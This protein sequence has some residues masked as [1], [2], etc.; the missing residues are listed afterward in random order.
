EEG[1]ADLEHALGEATELIADWLGTVAWL[2]TYLQRRDVDDDTALRSVFRYCLERM[3]DAKEWMGDA[4]EP[5]RI[6]LWWLDQ[7]DGD[8]FFMFSN[9]IRDDRT[10]SFRFSPSSGLMGQAFVENRIYNIEDAPSSSFYV[11]IRDADIDY[12]GLLLVPVRALDQPVGML[13]IDRRRSATFGE[14]AE[15]IATGLSELLSYAFVHP[16]VRTLM[17]AM[18]ERVDGLLLSWRALRTHPELETTPF[19]SAED[20]GPPAG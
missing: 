2:N 18:P 9:D 20:L 1:I 11:S 10:K 8:L 4:D 15:R 6:S 13:S 14:D 16:R 7:I 19:Q 12:H 3:E 17:R 5:I